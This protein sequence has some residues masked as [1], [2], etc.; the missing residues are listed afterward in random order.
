M[1]RR[2][3]S[4]LSPPGES[5]PGLA[6][7]SE[8]ITT[9]DG[10]LGMDGGL[11]RREA[12]G[13]LFTVIVAAQVISPAV[14]AASSVPTFA[15]DPT[16]G[17]K[18]T[19][20]CSS[21]SACINHGANKLFS[22]HE[23]ADRFSATPHSGGRAHPGCLC[24]VVAGQPLKPAVFKTIFAGTDFADRRDPAT[25]TLLS[26]QVQQHSV[27]LLTGALPLTVLAAGATGIVIVTARR[28]NGLRGS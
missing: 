15:L 19:S 12:I 6:Q 11:T 4:S 3:K 16:R 9:A 24:A 17:G 8:A 21:C 26:A 13:A 14:H 20:S 18:C 28:H 22:T 23:A 1:L 25:Q 7:L 5:E 27:P 10:S 2:P